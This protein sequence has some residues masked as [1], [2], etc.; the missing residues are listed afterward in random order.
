MAVVAGLP[1]CGLVV[2]WEPRPQ[3]DD[4]CEWLSAGTETG[5]APATSAG[6]SDAGGTDSGASSSGGGPATSQGSGGSSTTSST[7]AGGAGGSGGDG[8]GGSGG[9]DTGTGGSGAGGMGGGAGATSTGSVIPV[10][11]KSPCEAGAIT[12]VTSGV[13]PAQLHLGENQL[14]A[15]MV[16]WLGAGDIYFRPYLDSGTSLIEEAHLVA[17]GPGVRSAP[18][19]ATDGLHV[20]I[21]FGQA[22]SESAT[23]NLHYLAAA[24][25]ADTSSDDAPSAG[26][27]PPV[28]GSVLRVGAGRFLTAAVDGSG[29]GQLSLFQDGVHQSS[30]SVGSQ[31][32]FIGLSAL[33][34]GLTLVVMLESGAL[35][36]ATLDLDATEL[37]LNDVEGAAF[38]SPTPGQPVRV[39]SLGSGAALVWIEAEGVFTRVL[40]ATGALAHSG[41]VAATDTAVLP[42]VTSHAGEVSVSWLDTRNGGLNF[43]RLASDLSGGE[44]SL[45]I[46]TGVAN[47][48]YG[49]AAN[50][51]VNVPTYGL[52]FGKEQL[53]LW[54]VTC[55]E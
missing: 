16:A 5:G 49:L 30:S 15:W 12:D 42:H 55:E 20:A 24:D 7:Q 4:D 40:D 52:V 34:N 22:A 53:E 37:S 14:R 31:L 54:Q 6:G 48:P 38:G 50:N 41:Q 46:S 51:L 33:G 21:A 45:L 23:L 35:S 11:G 25:P 39:T 17:S 13:H 18:A 1:A 10:T 29:A 28:I 8:G 47:Q 43:R 44:E 26:N 32:E 27:D 2:G 19:L 9:R 3:C 36:L